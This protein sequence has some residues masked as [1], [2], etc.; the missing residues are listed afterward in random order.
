MLNPNTYIMATP[1]VRKQYSKAAFGAVLGWAA[2][3]TMAKLA[4]GDDVDINWDITNSDFGKVRIGNTRLDPGGSFLQFMV[5][6]GRSLIYGGWTSSS[7]PEE[8]MHKFGE[9]FQAETHFSNFERFAANKLNP[10]M[11]FAHDFADASEGKPFQVMDRTIQ[12]FVSLFAQDM[13]ELGQENPKLYPW[14]IPIAAGVGTQ[15]YEKGES[16]GKFIAPENDWTITGGGP[17]DWFGLN[18]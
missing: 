14:A 12:M 5:L 7:N 15:T 11:K 6:M 9:G 18:D 16:K 2:F 4:G 8:G 3:L 13:Y 1:F 10:V 17:M